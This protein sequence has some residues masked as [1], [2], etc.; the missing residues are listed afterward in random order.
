MKK[1]LKLLL[2]PNSLLIITPII[3]ELTLK[4]YKYLKNNKEKTL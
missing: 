3:I 1:E 2:I 4:I